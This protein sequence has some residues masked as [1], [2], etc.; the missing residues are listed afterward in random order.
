MVDLIDNLFQ[1]SGKRNPLS[2]PK[3]STIHDSLTQTQEDIGL[4]R[5][6]ENFPV[7][8]FKPEAVLKPFEG[9]HF[10]ILRRIA[11]VCY[12]ADP[13]YFFTEYREQLTKDGERVIGDFSSSECFKIL[14]EQVRSDPSL[15]K[16]AIPLCI[17][18]SLDK[19]TLN[20][21]RSRCAIPLTFWIFNLSGDQE[22]RSFKCE[23]LG[24]APQLP[25]NKSRLHE[26][27]TAQGCQGIGKRNLAIKRAERQ[28]LLNYLGQVLKPLIECQLRGGMVLQIGNSSSK[29]T[30]NAVPFLVAMIGDNEGS[31]YITGT[32]NSSLLCRCRVCN[33]EDC[34]SFMFNPNDVT[35]TAT[36]R[37]DAVTNEHAVQGATLELKAFNGSRLSSEE[38]LTKLR[39][40]HLNIASAAHNPLYEAFAATSQPLTRLPHLPR[41]GL[42]HSSP[43]DVL[44]TFLKGSNELCLALVMEIVYYVQTL[45]ADKYKSN[46]SQLD[47]RIASINIDQSLPA[48]RMSKFGGGLSQF[49]LRENAG[50]MTGGLPAW[51][52]KSLLL[53]LQICIGEDDAILPNKKICFGEVNGRKFNG[54]K[55]F[56]DK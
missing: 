27:L 53:Q 18:F 33:Q 7:D 20:S 22:R 4:K 3:Y 24:Y 42:H 41:F 8:Y 45:D 40:K 11:E 13:A 5:F 36:F 32:S 14:T 23:F 1:S 55:L 48:M 43:P 21:S 31:S 16:D 17:A 30:V 9:V 44:H 10:D 29:K 38:N 50:S 6:V 54:R 56:F 51:K 2:L 28:S 39:V 19:T 37:S 49:F 46:V 34:S 12:F 47:R 52:L 15:P 26:V 25:E 35:S